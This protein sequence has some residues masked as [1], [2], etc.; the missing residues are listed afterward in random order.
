M[1]LNFD[2]TIITDHPFTPELI[3]QLLMTAEEMIAEEKRQLLNGADPEDWDS[4]ENKSKYLRPLPITEKAVERFH[5]KLNPSR[6]SETPG[7]RRQT[8]KMANLVELM[9]KVNLDTSIQERQDC[10]KTTSSICAI[11]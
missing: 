6:G 10:D 4:A 2:A 7:L 1:K 5:K 3:Q 9:M 8:N 11:A